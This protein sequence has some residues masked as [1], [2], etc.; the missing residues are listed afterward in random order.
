MKTVLLFLLLGFFS[1]SAQDSPTKAKPEAPKPSQ[2]ELETRFKSALDNVTFRGR[3]C[4]VEEGKLGSEKKD[5]YTILGVSK[6]GADAW[7]LRAR[8][9]YGDKDL[10]APIPLQVKWAGDTPVII[11]DKFALPGGD[12]Y[13]ARVMIFNG[14]YAG[15]WSGTDYGG[16]L[17]GVIVPTKDPTK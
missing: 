17:N 10:V 12:T 5:Q 2:E 3:W 11:V 15:S 16:L 8:I 13:S 4:S 14:T 1:V 7:I 9:Q 6:I